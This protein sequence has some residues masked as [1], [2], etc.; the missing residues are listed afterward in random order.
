[1]IS[2]DELAKQKGVKPIS[3]DEAAR[4]AG[5]KPIGDTSQ[6]KIQQAGQEAESFL[7]KPWYKKIVTP[8]FA[9]EVPQ[10]TADVAIGTPAK[11]LA[12]TAEVPSIFKTGKATKKEYKVP[13]L[14]P[15]KSY[16]S[17]AEVRAGE[18]IEGKKPVYSALEPFITVPL[19]GLETLGVG[20]GLFKTGQ[21]TAAVAETAIDTY[22]KNAATKAAKEFDSLTGMITQGKTKDIPVAQKA[23]SNIDISGIK[24]YKDAVSTVDGKIETIATKLDDA[25]KTDKTVH[26]FETLVSKKHNFVDDAL[27]QL[28]DF[29]TKTNDIAKKEAVQSMILKAK[30]EGLTVK[31]INDIA[32]LHGQDLNAYNASGEL[33]SGLTKQAA[34][35]TRV[36]VKDT[37][38]TLFN[39]PAFKAAD[40]EMS[41]LIRVKDLF[42]KQTEEVNKLQQKILPRTLG[43]KAGR[44]I[45]QIV[46]TL[47]G[48]APKGAVEYF[49]GRGTGLKTLNAL[50]LE[51]NLQKN[52]KNLQKLSDPNLSDEQ[53]I[54]ELERIS[55]EMPEWQK[56][57]KTTSENIKSP[58]LKSYKDTK[59][60]FKTNK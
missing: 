3:L 60:I 29:Y 44:L 33:A 45:S 14:S 34:E 49:L 42:K 36:G 11:F 23:L 46:N 25:L 16:Q 5:V 15:F 12:S 7:A 50:D 8:E 53:L 24:T 41:N 39:N 13:G 54:K 59:S 40:E 9:K 30:N 31:E 1:M 2:L 57:F 10:A 26:P 6:D 22:K 47:G 52:L 38:R 32:K 35:N 58:I 20:K 27:K 18:I 21:K 51:K 4:Q 19:A 55:N 56:T 17:E 37:A 28:D 48:N 43:E